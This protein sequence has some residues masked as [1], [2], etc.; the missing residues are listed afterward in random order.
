MN[1]IL[2][3][4]IVEFTKKYFW[5]FITVTLLLIFVLGTSVITSVDSHINYI[6]HQIKQ[7]IMEYDEID[8]SHICNL[9]E[10]TKIYTPTETFVKKDYLT[11]I[12]YEKPNF[13][14]ISKTVY[15]NNYHL[16][17]YNEEAN[18]YIEKIFGHHIYDIIVNLSIIF[19]IFINIFSWFM[20]KA[21]KR[22]RNEAMITNIGNEAILANK[23]MI[24]ITENV[25]HEL[26]TPIDVIENKIEKVHRTLNQYIVSQTEWAEKHN[27]DKRET[28]E[29]RKWNQKII[30]LEKDFD[31]IHTSIEQI[32]SVLSKM[33]NF[34]NL[35]YSNGDKSVY[36][37]IE[38]AFRIISVSYSNVSY[39]IDDEFKKYKM[40]KDTLKNIDLL[41]VLINH[42]KN[43]LEAQA[44]EI[45]VNMNPNIK[46]NMMKL[47]ITDNGSGISEEIKKN[48]FNPNFSSKQIGDSIRGNGMYLNKHIVKEFGGDIKILQTSTKGTSV[49][50]SFRVNIKE[51]NNIA[52]KINNNEIENEI[53]KIRIKSAKNK[54]Y[55]Y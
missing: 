45:K 23:S 6:N 43:S 53:D 41:N 20:Y 51:D 9:S 13:L 7:N 54:Q 24:M 47:V 35:R 16:V 14:K 46:K 2:N 22:E 12:N 52:H 15:L 32:L 8:L 40:G 25:H 21:Y 55:K 4:N 28:V 34:K 50:I 3:N 5:Y 33:K 18:V 37:V 11:E 31:F 1:L 44:S 10:C 19:I 39:Y 38:G 42:I 48:V 26:N 36:N 30:K 27:M 17:F 29:S 49:E